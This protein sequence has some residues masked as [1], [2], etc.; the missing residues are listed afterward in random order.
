MTDPEPG[1]VPGSNLPVTARAP[2]KCILFGEHGVVRGTPELL[3]ALDLETQVVL[4]PAE[5]TQL[6]G[7]RDA[8]TAPGYF[9]TA[10]EEMWPLGRPLAVH[11]TSRVPRG[12]GLGSSAAFVAALAAG[13]GA[14]TGGIDRPTLARR[15][16]A[17]EQRAQ[18][19]GSPGDTTASVAG[20]YVAL[21]DP[22]GSELWTLEDGRVKWTARRIPDPGW[23]W[24]VAYSGI[25]RAAPEA[26]RSVRDRLEQMDGPELLRRFETVAREGIRALGREDREEV[27]ARLTENHLLLREVGVSHP[28]LEALLEAAGPSM[29]GGKLTGAGRGGSVVALPFPG[30][31][32]DL[33]RRIARAGG[34]PYIVRPSIRGAALTGPEP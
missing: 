8:A 5:R 23:L 1:P 20:G 28:R 34:V 29:I 13:L 6:N 19:I 25:P 2:G 30:R 14:A 4:Q 17:I 33:A 16:F 11:T 31:E 22:S 15:S 26:I 12:S 7:D 21:N 18:G 10:L 9:R 3:F 27:G 32:L 24:V